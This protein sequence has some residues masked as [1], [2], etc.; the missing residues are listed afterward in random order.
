MAAVPY[1]HTVREN[2]IE[3]VAIEQQPAPDPYANVIPSETARHESKHM[4]VAVRRGVGIYFAT[5]VPNPSAGYL[6]AV[7]TK[8]FDGPTFM[9]A[10]ADH[11][12][13]TGHDVKVASILGK[14]GSDASTAKGLMDEDRSTV[15]LFARALEYHGTMDESLIEKV[16]AQAQ[17]SKVPKVKF[18]ARAETGETFEITGFGVNTT[19][20]ELPKEITDFADRVLSN[21]E[22]AKKKP[23]NKYDIDSHRPWSERI[24]S[25]ETT[26]HDQQVESARL[27]SVGLVVAEEFDRIQREMRLQEVREELADI[28]QTLPQDNFD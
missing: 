25:R 10:H 5:R 6:G 15:D 21:T 26:A 14:P 13:G 28:E 8:R 20:G 1:G 11:E 19:N 23:E 27:A 22:E 9:A 16:Y 12:N 24:S 18:L 7:Y 2:G 3:V 17:E 4:Y